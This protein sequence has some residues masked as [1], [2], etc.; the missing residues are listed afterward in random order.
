MSRTGHNKAW[1]GVSDERLVSELQRLIP[2]ED[3]QRKTLS[4]ARSSKA[5][6]P[7]TGIG[8][9]TVADI[10]VGSD[11]SI[12]GISPPLIELDAAGR[13]YHNPQTLTSSD[14]LFTIEVKPI[15]TLYLQDVNGRSVVLN[16]DEPDLSII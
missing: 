9:L 15:A 7:S 1:A 8:K 4:P 12:R 3:K 6:Q 11:G 2:R 16:L 13:E 10:G 14:G 5:I